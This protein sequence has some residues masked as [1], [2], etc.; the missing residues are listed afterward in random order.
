VLIAILAPW[1]APFD[2]NQQVF[3]A[4]L[5]APGPVHWFGT[6]NFG[7]D[8]F[9][10]VLWGT[11]IDLL[12][13]GLGVLFPFIIGTFIGA[14]AGYYGGLVDKV[15]MRILD[16]TM[17]FPFF[18]LIIAIVAILGAGL[19]TFFIAVA[20][21]GWVSYARL[22]RA[23]FLVLKKSDFI[24]AARCLGFPNRRIMLWH[25]LPNAIMPALVFSMSDAVIDVLLGSSLSYLGLGVP[26]PTAE[27]GLMIAESQ[28]F[29]ANAWWMTVFPG[30]AIVFLALGFS[31][32]A[33]GLAEKLDVVES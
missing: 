4:T 3:T 31:L 20:L 22:V 12:M 23:Q 27:W 15:L 24:T 10:R 19:V 8:I 14:I 9:S 33:D 16:V 26:P 17:S 28:N 1:I 18:V 32:L 29:I 5:Q 21:V 30:L 7:R 11:R 6:D 25:L 2:P 13:G